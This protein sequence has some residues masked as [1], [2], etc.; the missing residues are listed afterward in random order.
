MEQYE[1][2]CRNLKRYADGKGVDAYSYELLD[3]FYE[4][5]AARYEN[6]EICPEYLRFIQRVIRMLRTLAETGEIDFRSGGSHTKYRVSESVGE[7]IQD[8]LDNYA[9]C[10]EAPIE[11]DTVI[12]HLFSH[13]GAEGYRAHALTDGILM[14]FFTQELPATNKG[15]MGRPLR[16]IKYVSDYFQAHGIGN[17]R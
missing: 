4:Q 11:M 8:I 15:S 14:K 17:L 16:A 3:G 1:V 10:G 9:L 7:F 13:A 6:K 5:E 2:V 12:R